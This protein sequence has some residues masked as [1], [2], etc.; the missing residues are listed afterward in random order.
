MNEVMG[1]GKKKKE[2]R[3]NDLALFITRNSD[4]TEI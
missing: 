1:K 3:I 4:L 2:N